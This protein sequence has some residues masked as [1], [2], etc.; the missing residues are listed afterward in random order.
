[1]YISNYIGKAIAYFREKKGYSTVKLAEYADMSQGS[2]SLYENGK[3]NPSH[4]SLMKIA[5]ALGIDV[6]TI[7]EKALAFEKES[8]RSRLTGH[9]EQE[10]SEYE[11]A[12]LLERVY[13]NSDFVLK[14]G[15][16]LL[17][18]VEVKVHQL[19]RERRRRSRPILIEQLVENILGDFLASHADE[20]STRLNAEFEQL[21]V[22][23]NRLVDELR[24]G[25]NE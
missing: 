5:A 16:E 25:Y 17:V 13:R 4:S 18:S 12:K 15:N 6:N 10:V 8:F 14:L 19:D 22:S 9:A 20:L 7:A 1:M 24:N 11:K 23:K 21:E 2:I 3:R